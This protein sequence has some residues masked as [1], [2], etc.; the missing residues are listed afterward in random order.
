MVKGFAIGAL[1][2]GLALTGCSGQDQKPAAPPELV[3]A[4]ALDRLLLSPD[5][6][7]GIMGVTGMTAHPRVDVMGDHR[8]LL[9]NLNCLGIWQVNESGVYG[10]DGWIALRQEL[11]R[12]PDTDDWHVLVVQS[13]VNYP[14]T[15]AAREFFDQSADRW[16][17]CT[18]HTVNITLNDK[19]LPKWHSGDL[20]KTDT[21]LAIPFTRGNAN[22]VDSCQRVLA[23]DDNVIIDAQACTRDAAIVTQAAKVAEAIEA[24]LPH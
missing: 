23:V 20:T 14:S 5:E 12:T 10:K 18:N 3:P 19:P 17:K 6:V 4:N 9:P 8:N 13:V 16:A 21:Q 15:D 2:L 7:D 1:S 22:G 11:L 24:K